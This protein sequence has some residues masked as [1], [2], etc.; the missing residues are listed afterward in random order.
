MRDDEAFDALETPS[1]GPERADDFED[2]LLHCLPLQ[3]SGSDGRRPVAVPSGAAAGLRSLR[4]PCC[5]V[6]ASS[7][8]R[9]RLHVPQRRMTP[10]PL[11][12]APR[13]EA[14][15]P[16]TPMTPKTPKKMAP[17]QRSAGEDYRQPTEAWISRLG[18]GIG[19]L[20]LSGCPRMRAWNSDGMIDAA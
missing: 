2:E 4:V 8:L 3:E 6:L 11:P 15:R 12:P 7:R 14:E 9:R 13:V 17:K 18:R 5:S 10:R 19:V 1:F 16:K 20:E